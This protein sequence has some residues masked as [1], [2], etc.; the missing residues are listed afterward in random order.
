ML[1]GAHPAAKLILLIILALVG[2]F[3]TMIIGLI[4]AI[5]FF[6]PD[7]TGIILQGE[8]L[9]LTEN[10]NFSRYFQTLSHIGLFVVPSVVFAILVGRRPFLYL[11]AARKP[12][13]VSLGVSILIMI[14]ALPLVNFLMEINLKLSLP[15]W[16]SGL[17]GWMRSAE[18]NAEVITRMFLEVSSYEALL[19]NI[20]MIAVIPAIGEEFI[21]RGIVLRLF[22]QWT[23]SAHAAVWISALLFSAM[24]MQFF[25]FLPRL[26][27]G[28]VLGY[29]FV[30]SRNIW[31]P[32][33]AHFF[34]N[35]AAVI[36]YF[37]HH[38]GYI[39]IDIE[40]VGLGAGAA[41]YVVASV[42]LLVLLSALFW[43]FESS[44]Q[45]RLSFD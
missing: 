21:F 2:M 6:G 31:V 15:A 44:R 13:F 37:M 4:I 35:A 38:N 1:G 30:W 3:F 19:F 9:D 42:V 27:L 20:F 24:H 36:F 16:M 43:N 28:L 34:N 11:K 8:G 18:E 10:L 33:V 26:F 32:V 12:F 45:K 17:E 29:M 23:G 7:I 40:E 5:P 39:N 41:Y 25:G 22:R 14:A